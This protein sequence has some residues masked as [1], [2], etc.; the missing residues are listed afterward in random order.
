[1]A[2]AGV[3]NSIRGAMP[4]NTACDPS[5]AM[6]RRMQCAM[7]GL[8]A[9]G[10]VAAMGLHG[11]LPTLHTCVLTRPDPRRESETGAMGCEALVERCVIK[12]PPGLVWP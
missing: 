11:P 2:A 1:M 4:L 3:W 9:R 6:M 7:L 8:P 12:A 5:A 10:S